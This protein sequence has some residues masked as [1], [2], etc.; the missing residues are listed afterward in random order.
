MRAARASGA[1]ALVVVALL[2]SA[3]ACSSGGSFDG[4]AR[5]PGGSGPR[6]VFDLARAPEPELPWPNDLLA[7][8]DPLSPTGLRVDLGLSAPT[9]LERGLRGQL[10]LR[11]GFGTFAPLTV[12]FDQELDLLDLWRRQNDGDPS[13]DALY[14][15]DLTSGETVP[16]EVGGGRFPYELVQPAPYFLGDPLAAATNLLFPVDGPLPNLLH[17]PDPLWPESHGGVPQQSDD[18]LTF[19]ERSTRTLI[20]RPL[21][22]LRQRRTYAVLLTERLV[23]TDGA[24]VVSPFPGINHAAQTGELHRLPQLL[25]AGLSLSQVRFTWAFTT[26]SVTSD[27]EAVRDGL[28]GGGPLSALASRVPVFCT[29]DSIG[30]PVDRCRDTSFDRVS[31]LTLQPVLDATSG[32]VF[33]LPAGLLAQLLSD[34]ALAPL[35]GLTDPQQLQAVQA[36][37]QYVDHFVAGTFPSPDL[38]SD[39][40]RPGGDAAFALDPALGAVRA[41]AV[42]LPFL[43]AVPRPGSGLCG[44]QALPCPVHSA[45]FPVVIAGHRLGGSRLEPQLQFAGTFAKFG[46]ATL[47]LDAWGHGPA[48]DPATEVQ[49]RAAFAAHGLSALGTALLATRARDLANDGLKQPGGDLFSG[50]PVHTRDA[51]R[52]SVIDQLQASR[53]LRSFDGRNQMLHPASASGLAVAGDFD[54][55][56]V[57]DVGGPAAFAA[58]V[59]R[60][61]DGTL[62]F[63]KG[64][65]DPGADQFAFGV[66]L[67]GILASIVPALEPS[68]RAASPVSA[69]GGLADLFLRTGAQQI[70]RAVLL[71]A[72]GPFVTSCSWSA[73][74]QRCGGAGGVPALVFSA[75]RVDAEA[76]LP[77]APAALQ[78]GDTVTACDLAQQLA[79]AAASDQTGCVAARVD[80]NG[81]LLLPLQADGPSLL[82]SEVPAQTPG[83]PGQVSVLVTRPGDLL[84]L[85]VAHAGAAPA[86]IA[87]FSWDT[88]LLGVGYA[89]GSP[90]RVPARGF[91]RGRNTPGLRRLLATYQAILD[92]ADPVNY[93]PHWSRDPLPAR[94][95]APAEVL[96]VAM[97]GDPVVPTSTGVALGRAA[98]LVELTAADPGYGLPID[99]LLQQSGTTE[100]LARLRRLQDGTVGPRALLG[101]HLSCDSPADCSGEVLVDPS[102]LSCDASGSCSDGLR[103][104]RLTPP[105]RAQLQRQDHAADGT[106]AG[107]SMLLLPLASRQG[108]HG[109]GAPRPQQPFDLDQLLANQAGRFF[110]SRGTEIRF[111]PCQTAPAS[112]PWIAQPPP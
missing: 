73:A 111:E 14:L 62:L 58:A 69:G 95:G 40:D 65:A 64:A 18:L 78:P 71:E 85:T 87:S 34:P 96:L 7:R 36:S 17:P 47:S 53:L 31:T 99:Q 92:P 6:V 33:V 79:A 108:Q 25:P 86:V 1:L 20:V 35:F 3:T 68:V 23:G 93:A 88:Q 38:L 97:A 11:D 8:P 60:S 90:L 21:V 13:N 100:G 66:S 82:A 91:G 104:P 32:N 15:V 101:A 51:I 55:D 37:L 89:A 106:A 67:G 41:A 26:Q 63:A 61:S 80:A 81:G 12:S 5:S 45:P 27:L 19:Y 46:L 16:L 84:R 9:Q 107:L 57:P 112:C 72:M 10:D 77:I 102:G 59:V 52:Q 43:L 44:P 75:Q 22:P 74:E 56:G 29:A 110:E 83:Q 48:L 94:A 70:E 28:A 103:A 30:S 42:E 24:P 2:S 76:V 39:P 105:L 50:D 98:G 109:Y 4:L 49:V 54:L